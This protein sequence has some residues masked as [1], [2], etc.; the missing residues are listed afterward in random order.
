MRFN[1]QYIQ[2]KLYC[3]YYMVTAGRGSVSGEENKI[4]EENVVILYN[5]EWE[6]CRSTYNLL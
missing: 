1:N 4:T 6:C 3:H 2:S 5:D